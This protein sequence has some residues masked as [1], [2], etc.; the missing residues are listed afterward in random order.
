MQTVEHTGERLPP[1]LP[2]PPALR[3]VGPATAV[4]MG[5][6]VLV[7]VVAVLVLAAPETAREPIA[8]IATL[9]LLLDGVDG[10]VA[11]RTG[12]ASA[13]GGRLDMEVDAALVLVL[14]V[15]VAGRLG[16][17]WILLVGLARYLLA[18]ATWVAPWTGSP[19]PQRYWRKVV[20]V[21]QV[22]ALVAAG[23]GLVG[24]PAARWLLGTAGAALLVSFVTQVWEV[25]GSRPDPSSPRGAVLT[26]VAVL[27]CWLVLAAPDDPREGLLAL[28]LLPVEAVLAVVVLL[29]AALGPQWLRRLVEGVLVAALAVVALLRVADLGFFVTLGRRSDPWTDVGRTGSAVSGALD[30]FGPAVGSLVV[31]LTVL[32]VVGLA[33]VV[34]G[35]GRRVARLVARRP[36]TARR[37]VV[38]GAATWLTAATLGLTTSAATPLAGRST[39]GLV[40][41]HVGQV[42]ANAVDR[43][44]FAVQ[45]AADPLAAG[46]R[47]PAALAGKDVLVVFVE[48]YGRYAV[49]GSPVA[50]GVTRVLDRGTATLASAG[51]GARSAFLTSPTYGGLSWLAHSTLQSGL[52]VDRQ[53]RYDVLLDSSRTTLT[54]LFAR[55][56]WRTA[57][58][59]PANR[60]DWEPARTFYGCD[61]TYDAR[62]LGYDGPAFGYPPVPDA[63]TLAAFARREL[64]PGHAPVMAEIDLVTSHAPWTPL[65]PTLPWSALRHGQAY[66]SAARPPDPAGGQRGAYGAGIE[67]SLDS[68]VT[69]V[70]NAGDRNL[71]L[72]VLGDHQPYAAVT[73][74]GAGHD[75][76]VSV[77]SSD[78]AVLEAIASWGWSPGLRPSDDAPVWRM[79]G[80]R[81]RFLE[82]FQNR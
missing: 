23:S 40:S 19:V 66:D 53:G 64:G 38:A 18:A 74:T 67:Y 28:P 79:D 48:S 33:A 73:G 35:A 72:V 26:G 30:A 17:G 78:P 29:A 3:R 45:I 11:R 25:R 77:V 75:V 42:R 55:S 59:V 62:N 13:F 6:A 76:P 58:V 36:R 81:G 56:G 82:A 71:V 7:A 16:I 49:Q 41:A 50:A 2:P 4:T 22:V 10:W 63:F 14:A 8:V 46:A 57:C 15:H 52:W 12:T 69:F 24:G 20:A 47:V 54:G 68:L 51:F 44:A 5:R 65:P 31:V 21:A 39:V 80:F 37:W 70:A 60:H 34:A 1:A 61:V 32:S 9:A 27:V 43:A